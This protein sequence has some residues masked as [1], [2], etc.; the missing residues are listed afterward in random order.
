MGN[1]VKK[2]P[3]TIRYRGTE[4]DWRKVAVTSRFWEY[5]DRGF[6]RMEYLGKNG[7]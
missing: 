6:I 5:V 2:S 3:V 4:E 1:G 7:E